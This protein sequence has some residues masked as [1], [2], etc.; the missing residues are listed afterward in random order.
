MEKPGTL[1]LSELKIY[2]DPMVQN[3]SSQW[4]QNTRSDSKNLRGLK[5]LVEDADVVVFNLSPFWNQGSQTVK[6]EIKAGTIVLVS[7]RRI[8]WCPRAKFIF[9][10]A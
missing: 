5:S 6:L 4:N 8:Q 3:M 10:V 9:A 1:D 7:S 2:P